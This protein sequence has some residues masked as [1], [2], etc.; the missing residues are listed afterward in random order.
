MVGFSVQDFYCRI[1]ELFGLEEILKI[2]FQPPCPRQGHL[3]LHQVA[4]K[5]I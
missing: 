3:F 1:M 4:Q 2:R 5:P